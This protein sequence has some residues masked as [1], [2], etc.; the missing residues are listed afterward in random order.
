VVK[1]GLREIVSGSY[2]PAGPRFAHGFPQF[3]AFEVHLQ[4]EIVFESGHF[5]VRAGWIMLIAI[6]PV[7]AV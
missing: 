5:V 3:P 6:G 7:L 4:D 1:R 2:V